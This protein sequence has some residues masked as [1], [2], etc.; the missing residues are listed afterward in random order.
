[1]DNNGDVYQTLDLVDCAFQAG[2]VNEIS[3]GVELCSRGDKVEQGTYPADLYQRFP[4]EQVTC[5]INGHQWLALNYTKES[6]QSMVAM[7]RALARVLP[8]LPEVCP[9][10]SDG[11]PLW[12]T[13]DGDPREFSGYLGHYHVTNQKWDPGPW[14]FKRLIQ[15]I[16]GRIFYPSVP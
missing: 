12:A 15:S 10:G 13:L 3:I 5:T 2:G 11:E 16:R 7:A 8:A 6:V 4:R 9:Q 14:D 1:I